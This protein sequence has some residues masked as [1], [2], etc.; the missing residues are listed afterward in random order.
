MGNDKH[1]V[2]LKVDEDNNEDEIN[3]DHEWKSN[4]TE[5][6]AVTNTDESG[7]ECN[8]R[9]ELSNKIRENVSKNQGIA[10]ERAE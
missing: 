6:T 4:D 5:S 7:Y 10:A 1:I 3:C 2:E 8:Y 9:I